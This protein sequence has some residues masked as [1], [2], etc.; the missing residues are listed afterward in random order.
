MYVAV[1]TVPAWLGALAWVAA[2]ASLAAAVV[3]LR[4]VPTS[5]WGMVGGAALIAAL[6]LLEFPLHDRYALGGSVVAAGFAVVVFGVDVAV[7]S[8]VAAT[9]ASGVVAAH[10]DWAAVGV[11]LFAHAAAAPWLTW[12]AYINLK[13]VFPSEAAGYVLAFAVGAA[14]AP[15]VA[16]AS[17]AAAFAGGFAT[18]GG[19]ARALLAGLT[20]TA[21]EGVLAAW[22]YALA[23][24]RGYRGDGR[25]P[26][27]RPR[28]WRGGFWLTVAALVL[29]AG[30]APFVPVYGGALGP[31]PALARAPELSYA[32]RVAAGAGVVAAAALFACVIFGVVAAARARSGGREVAPGGF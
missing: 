2:A 6:G 31:N 32:A 11:N 7:C 29:A 17:L 21:A 4:R 28:S 3:R 23:S 13:R 14:G 15:A 12:W 25:A 19:T 8:L 27:W 1:G 22:G 20:L 16:L 9:L 26:S 30:V 10:L 18:S 24:S 5:I